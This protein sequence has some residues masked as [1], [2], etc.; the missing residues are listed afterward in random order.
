[1]R[2]ITI[3]RDAPVKGTVSQNYNGQNCYQ[4]VDHEKPERRQWLGPFW[5][6]GAEKPAKHHPLAILDNWQTWRSRAKRQ[7]KL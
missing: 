4:Q 5:S 2:P 6:A 3:S 7:H 1:M